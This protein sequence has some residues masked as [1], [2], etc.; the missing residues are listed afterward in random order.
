[1]SQMTLSEELQWRG[2]VNQTTFKDIKAI[3]G[4]P[5]TFYLGMDPSAKS[6]QIGNLAIAMMIRH[7]ISRGHKAVMLVG[8][9]TGLIGDPDG[10]DEERTLKPIEEIAENKASIARQY[11]RIFAGMPFQHVDNYDWFKDMGYLQFLR[12]VGKHVPMS[13]MLQRQFV[14]TRLGEGGAGISYAEFSYALIQGYDFVHLNRHFGVTLQLCGSDQWGNSMAGVELLRRM[15]GVEGHVWSGPLV[16]NRSTGKKFGKSEGGAVWLDP[17]MTSPTAFYQFWINCDDEGVEEYIKFY[18]MLDKPTV[19]A[20]MIKHH[21]N[22][23]ARLAQTVLA[24][25]VTTLVHGRQAMEMAQAVTQFIT[26]SR[27]I[28][29]ASDEQLEVIRRELPS[30]KVSKD[31]NVIDVLV[32]V[33]LATSKTDARRLLLG[34]AV[35]INNQK[36]SDELLGD[37]M[38]QN[39]K[40]LIRKGRAF[41]DSALVELS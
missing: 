7:F 5:I 23:G 32:A 8:G 35:A 40:L 24:E 30:I 17:D 33:G 10:K 26:G 11:D 38:F 3:D 15:H 39:N 25:E 27:A 37:D 6:L 31:A 13:D 4:E 9:A 36:I 16:I 14:S 2:F 18:T 28:S 12:E 21:Q 20:L 1:M 34:N 22:A 19:D 41:K 29:D